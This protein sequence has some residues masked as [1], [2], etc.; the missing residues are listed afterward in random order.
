MREVMEREDDALSK[1]EGA[2][3]FVARELPNEPIV[4]ALISRPGS[5][6]DSEVDQG[7]EGSH[8]VG[9][10]RSVGFGGAPPISVVHRAGTQAKDI[11]A[12][13]NS[14]SASTVRP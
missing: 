2:M 5:I 14:F 9:C 8:G 3:I 1:V 13:A 10:D 7:R 6:V 12:I 4:L 11:G